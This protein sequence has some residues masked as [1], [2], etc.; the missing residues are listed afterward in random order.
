MKDHKDHDS[1]RD[2]LFKTR[3]LIGIWIIAMG[4]IFLAGNLGWIDTRHAFRLFWPVLFVF[5]GTAMVSQQSTRRAHRWGWVFI[6]VGIWLFAD[7]IGWVDVNFWQIAFPVALLAVGGML[8]WR[9]FN[10]PRADL[11]SREGDRKS[12]V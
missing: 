2:P 8:V 7:R 1:N 4:A 11:L 9:A 10:G 3:L 12:V 6:T 5:I